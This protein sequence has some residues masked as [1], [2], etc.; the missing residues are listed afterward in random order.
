MYEQVEKPKKNKS[1]AIANSVV[2][3]KNEVKQEKRLEDNREKKHNDVVQ[4]GKNGKKKAAMERN[5][6]KKAKAQSMGD[7]SY[8]NLCDY[9]S[10][11]IKRNNI[12]AQN[13][14]DFRKTYSKGIRGHASGN[15]NDGEQGNTTED[16]KA[17]KSWHTTQFGW[18]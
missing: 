13:V 17:Y 16:C 12:T 3:K 5:A 7:R 11:W 18:S 15:N 8:N 1:R 9:R 2:N 10:G 6:N 4:L 14:K